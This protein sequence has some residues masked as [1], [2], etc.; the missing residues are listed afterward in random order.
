MPKTALFSSLAACSAAA[1]GASVTD[2]RANAYAGVAKICWA[3]EF[4]RNDVGWRAIVREQQ[5]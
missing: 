5:A 1:R 3:N 2:A 4:H